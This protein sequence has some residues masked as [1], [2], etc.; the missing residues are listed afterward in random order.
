MDLI[1]DRDV[2]MLISEAIAFVNIQEAEAA[3]DWKQRILVFTAIDGSTTPKY[4]SELTLFCDR[5][6]L[7]EWILKSEYSTNLSQ[8]PIWVNLKFSLL[9]LLVLQPKFNEL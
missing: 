9:N 1:N 4:W 6:S 2:A 3:H 8:F 5:A 7:V